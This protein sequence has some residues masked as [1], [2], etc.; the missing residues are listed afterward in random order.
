MKDVIIIGGG[1]AA[2]SAAIYAARAGLDITLI[3]EDIGGYV[4]ETDVIENYLGFSSIKGIDLAKQFKQHMQQYTIECIES[5][6]K[7]VVQEGETV[8]I[9]YDDKTITGKTAIVAS[10]SKRKKLGV[11]G[12]EKF[13]KHGVT[14]C[15]V[16]DGP[17]FAGQNVAVIGGGDSGVKAALY[18]SNIAKKVYVLEIS[19]KLRGEK[20]LVDKITRS[21][22]IEVLVGAKTTEIF[23]EEDVTGLKYEKNGANILDVSGITIE[24]GI[25]PN[26][27]I[28]AVK[29]DA[30]GFILVDPSMKTS[31]DRIFA[32]GDVVQGHKQIIV[33]AAQGCIA[34]L[35]ICKILK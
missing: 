12:E 1:P 14:Y 21:E 16:C 22:N 4:A 11:P 18:L 34:A 23:G 5:Y 33:A 17:I 32:A 24:V 15:A 10:G 3:A 9:S 29:K 8:V 35:E 13:F 25:T 28:V 7:S 6:A 30:Y 31:S 26:S 20:V 2:L 27:D 19:D